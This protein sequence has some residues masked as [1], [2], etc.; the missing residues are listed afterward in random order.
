MLPAGYRSSQTAR[1]GSNLSK[2]RFFVQPNPI[3]M[4]RI[5]GVIHVSCILLPCERSFDSINVCLFVSNFNYLR[6]NLFAA[7]FFYTGAHWH[8]FHVWLISDLDV[9]TFTLLCTPI[10]HLT[11][12]L[13]G[14]EQSR[15]L[16]YQY[17]CVYIRSIVRQMVNQ[18]FSKNSKAIGIRKLRKSC[19]LK[20]NAVHTNYIF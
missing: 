7:Y 11:R 10:N 2:A 17:R 9:D 4:L 3:P 18:N 19:L 8:H 14:I 12:V 13:A 6:T 16:D 20:K 15:F 1:P 5:L